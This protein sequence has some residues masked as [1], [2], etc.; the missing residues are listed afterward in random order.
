M[1]AFIIFIIILAIIWICLFVFLVNKREKD[2][3]VLFKLIDSILD[4][5]CTQ[6]GT[7]IDIGGEIVK[8]I[9]VDEENSNLALV[10]K[11]N[12][13]FSYKIIPFNQVVS[14]EIIEDEI[15]KVK[16][17][18]L[19][20]VLDSISEPEFVFYSINSINP[21]DKTSAVYVASK[22]TI[23]QWHSIMTIVIKRGQRLPS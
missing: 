13:E 1:V 4:F 22:R 17:L 19:K 9:A 11:I 2:K 7:G 12:N 20:I 8:G 14:T 21:I 6:K 5:K 16:K 23:D 18:G 10:S 15:S 3:N